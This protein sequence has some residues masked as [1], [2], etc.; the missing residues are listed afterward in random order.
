VGESHVSDF[1]YGDQALQEAYELME[2]FGNRLTFQNLSLAKRYADGRLNLLVEASWG[3]MDFHILCQKK[4]A[5]RLTGSARI[6]E[7]GTTVGAGTAKTETTIW[8]DEH[9]GHGDL[10]R[11][12]DE[13]GSYD[14][15]GVVLVNDVQLMEGPQ[16]S[17]ASIATFKPKDETLGFGADALYFGFGTGFKALGP[18]AEG[19]ES[20]TTIRLAPVRSYQVADDIVERAPQ[21]VNGV[22]KKKADPDGWRQ[23]L[24]RHAVDVLAGLRI[25]L[26]PESVLVRRKERPD[27]SLKVG[28]VMFGPFNF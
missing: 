4:G 20:T 13:C 18:Q 26:M 28:D 23:F 7:H 10:G 14:Y 19:R 2:R 25:Y 6:A 27:F 15:D 3:A 11:N 12:A 5:P 17:V 16:D 22:A 9:A 21:I 1:K 24:A 8:T